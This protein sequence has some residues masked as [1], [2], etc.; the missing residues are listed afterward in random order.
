MTQEELKVEQKIID[1][2]VKTSN[3]DFI[4][5]TNMKMF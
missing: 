4:C 3:Y 2:G 5:S 1:F